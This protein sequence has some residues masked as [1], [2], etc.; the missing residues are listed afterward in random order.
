MDNTVSAI[1]KALMESRQIVEDQDG[2]R[3]QLHEPELRTN[4]G[5]SQPDFSAGGNAAGIDFRS[6]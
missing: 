5:Y 1:V 6:T 4:R 3:Y 2:K